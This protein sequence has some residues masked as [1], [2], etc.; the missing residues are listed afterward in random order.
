MGF[1]FSPWV[2]RMTGFFYCLFIVTFSS[3]FTSSWWCKYTHTNTSPQVSPY[4]EAIFYWV[5]FKSQIFLRMRKVFCAWTPMTMSPRQ[6]FYRECFRLMC[7]WDADPITPI[8]T[9]KL[10][11]I[12]INQV[13][14][15]GTF[16]QGPWQ[17]CNK[18]LFL[19]GKKKWCCLFLLSYHPKIFKKLGVG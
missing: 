12:L 15:E 7:T 6:S 5:D 4:N 17:R 8:T 10:V 11:F 18:C 9:K 19:A 16:A 13:Y 1:S 14:I 3:V 2:K